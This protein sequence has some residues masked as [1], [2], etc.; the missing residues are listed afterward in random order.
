M[1]VLDINVCSNVY[2][3]KVDKV[4]MHVHCSY[5]V[6]VKCHSL[7]VRYVQGPLKRQF[8]ESVPKRLIE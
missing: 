6:N 7:G 8:S 5:N 2:N 3:Y 4:D 1:Y